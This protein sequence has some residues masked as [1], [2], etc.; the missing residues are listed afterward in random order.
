MGFE[1]VDMFRK[2]PL[3]A[4]MP[5]TPYGQCKVLVGYYL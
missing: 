4:P 1:A 5:I 3:S 2:N